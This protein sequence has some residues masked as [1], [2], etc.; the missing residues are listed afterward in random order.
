MGKRK[1]QARG[2]SSV[3]QSAEQG[4]IVGAQELGGDNS[5]SNVPYVTQAVGEIASGIGGQKKILKKKRKTIGQLSKE[6]KARRKARLTK[7]TK[8]YLWVN[9][10]T[11]QIMVARTLADKIAAIRKMKQQQNKPKYPE[12]EAIIDSIQKVVAAELAK[13]AGASPEK[14]KE[15]VTAK[16]ET[17]TGV[18]PINQ[19]IQNISTK[20]SES[21]TSIDA[22]AE[23]AA[24]PSETFSED[25]G[26]VLYWAN[27][28]GM[29]DA[30][31]EAF[32][33]ARVKAVMLKEPAKSDCLNQINTLEKDLKNV[34]ELAQKEVKKADE[35]DLAEI[36]MAAKKTDITAVAANLNPEEA[37]PEKAES[38]TS[39]EKKTLGE[40]E[41]KGLPNWLIYGG[42]AVALATIVYFVMRKSSGGKNSD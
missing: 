39:D 33:T 5:G 31:K 35:N 14:V 20:G 30:V 10:E 38:K 2:G 34:Y 41:S 1:V 29:P 24:Q 15:I 11:S 37:K 26:D 8:S 27:A 16:G 32:K 25:S 22:I 18:N 36:S 12:S 17:I 19:V 4:R 42:G 9:P 40:S 7:L 23:K 28:E 3:S 13:K 21:V 6:A